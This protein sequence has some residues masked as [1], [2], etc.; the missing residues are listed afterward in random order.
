MGEA[1]V[2]DDVYNMDLRAIQEKCPSPSLVIFSSPL[3][4]R[5][6][7]K[8]NDSQTVHNINT[9]FKKADKFFW[10]K[11]IFVITC[12]EQQL[13]TDHKSITERQN[14]TDAVKS[15]FQSKGNPP[16]DVVC[17][18]DNTQDRF[19]PE[20]KRSFWDKVLKKCEQPSLILLTCFLS[21]NK[22]LPSDEEKA[23]GSTFT[24]VT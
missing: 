24:T 7:A 23:S 1:E 18:S 10:E 12:G 3:N 4:A 16:P 6:K 14:R 21:Q 22:I 2:G 17:I 5:T 19:L 8:R 9:I 11:S 15:I 13:A 20:E